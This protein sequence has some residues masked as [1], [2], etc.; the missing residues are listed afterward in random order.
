[1]SNQQPKP[2]PVIVQQCEAIDYGRGM[3]QEAFP[4]S[5]KIEVNMETNRF[6]RVL[7]T[8]ARIDAE[9][10]SKMIPEVV[11]VAMLERMRFQTERSG[12]GQNAAIDE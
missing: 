5:T 9:I 11:Q 7:E 2:K 4:N 1:M 8:D 10:L 3:L 6:L 12:E